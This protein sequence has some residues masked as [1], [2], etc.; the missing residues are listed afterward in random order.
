MTNSNE[1][2]LYPGHVLRRKTR[3]YTN[4]YALIDEIRLT[5]D[6]TGVII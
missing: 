3:G 4:N 1:P 2:I 5:L 6:C